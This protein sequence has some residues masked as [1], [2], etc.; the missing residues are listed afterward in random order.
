MGRGVITAW[1]SLDSNDNEPHRF[2]HYL[3][4]A[5]LVGLGENIEIANAMDLPL[6]QARRQ[7][8]ACC[9]RPQ[10]VLLP[11]A[12]LNPESP[13]KKSSIISYS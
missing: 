4:V 11:H 6:G 2:L 13:V 3:S 9:S 1:L 7:E 12:A 10:I 5:I 8:V